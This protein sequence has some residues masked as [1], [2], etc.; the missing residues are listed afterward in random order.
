MPHHTHDG[1][2]P[3][4]IGG[5][6]NQMFILV[7]AYVCGRVHGRPVY[8]PSSIQ[9][10]NPH[11]KSK[12]NY[13][14]TLFHH[15]GIILNQS[16]G[17]LRSSVLQHYKRYKPK[18]FGPWFPFEVTPGTYMDSYFQYYPPLTP[19][20]QDIRALFR[21]GLGEPEISETTAFLHIRRGDYLNHPNYHYIQ[22]LTY[23]EQAISLLQEKNS[24]ITHIK[25]FSDD[26]AWAKEQTLFASDMFSFSEQEDE[27]EA[28]KEMASCGGGAVLA[29]ST[30]SWWGA[31]LGAH[32]LRAP[33]I[34]PSR[35][36]AEDVPE[37]CPIEWIRI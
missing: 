28:L 4:L 30:F 29:N 2:F 19:Y 1:F 10:E 9:F 7:A 16:E 24:S 36:I 11:L 33:V 27:I 21:K 14:T 18:G 5:L 12:S 32:A 37:L 15:F 31:F 6:G 23:Y 26:I 34:Y 3:L 8:L 13:I 20:E 35:W 22:P 17:E 25:I